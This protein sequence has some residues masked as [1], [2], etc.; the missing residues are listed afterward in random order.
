MKIAEYKAKVDQ[1]AEL[2]KEKDPQK[3]EE[4]VR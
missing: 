4:Y 2:C 3:I 1:D